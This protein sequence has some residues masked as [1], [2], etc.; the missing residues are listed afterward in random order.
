VVQPS[1]ISGDAAAPELVQASAFP[2]RTAGGA[3]ALLAAGL[4]GLLTSR[5]VLQLLRRRPGQ[6]IP[7]PPAETHTTEAQLRTV[8]EPFTADRL[9]VTL[10]ALADSL[11]RAGRSLPQLTTVHLSD[12]MVEIRLRTPDAD[13]PPPFRPGIGAG[14]WFLSIHEADELLRNTE[15]V[16]S[17]PAPWPTLVTLGHD[18][19]NA[20]VLVDLEQAAS[21]AITTPDPTTAR[22]VLAALT[23]ELATSTWAD[24]LRVTVVGELEELATSLSAGRIRYVDS[25]AEL[26][27]ALQRRA[28]RTR[29]HLNDSG[30]T[31]LSA[32]RLDPDA[33]DA[34]TPEVVLIATD[35]TDDERGRLADLVT[36]LP[37]VA[38]AAVT[39]TGNPLSEWNLRLPDPN[40]AVLDPIG[41]PLRPQL[42]GGSEYDSV[43]KLL[44]AA[45]RTDTEPADWWDHDLDQQPAAQAAWAPE[46]SS[47]L[48][49]EPAPSQPAAEGSAEV[50]RAKWTPVPSEGGD[51]PDASAVEPTAAPSGPPAEVTH[52]HA[53]LD[54]PP[55]PPSGPWL[56]LL[57][58][59]EI[60]NAAGTVEQKRSEVCRRLAVFLALHPNG[61][62]GTTIDDTLVIAS[63]TRLSVLSRL[64]AWLGETP[65]GED[66]LPAAVGKK[67]RLHPDFRTDWDHFNALTKAGLNGTPTRN[68]VEALRLVKG[69]PMSSGTPQLYSW[70]SYHADQISAKIRDAALLVAERSIADSD[71]DQARWAVTTAH[72]AGLQHDEFLARAELRVERAAGNL[73]GIHAVVDRLNRTV[74]DLDIDLDPETLELMTEIEEFQRRTR[75]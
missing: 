57:G 74:R 58:P 16:D 66:Y 22:A 59:V 15:I 12:T 33:A 36:A 75:A 28:D 41:L 10:R 60:H 55:F 30:L 17:T 71:I 67:Y 56:Q 2:I 31:S 13:A 72:Q 53:H 62:P 11:H 70:A 20:H 1:P 4:I 29:E 3:G 32:A 9:N 42:L 18:R 5:K 35:L 63:S 50:V 23:V 8:A 64:R 52:I 44:R 65:D 19:R 39:A 69:R 54:V 25:P 26:L 37:R 43:L 40:Q 14:S 61:T 68:L 48:L 46:P 34:L 51:V 6:A 47:A 73:D 27:S 21:L 45:A 49:S 38:V 7:A 24:D